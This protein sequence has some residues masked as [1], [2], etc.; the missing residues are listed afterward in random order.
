MRQKRPGS[1]IHEAGS[2]K[3]TGGGIGDRNRFIPG[4]RKAARILYGKR[5]V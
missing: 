2:S 4:K 3:K 1:P 5:A